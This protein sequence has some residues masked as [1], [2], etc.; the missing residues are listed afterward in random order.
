M[1]LC[2][3]RE[4]KWTIIAKTITLSGF[5][6]LWTLGKPCSVSNQ[7]SSG[8]DLHYF[9]PS[10]LD[11]SVELKKV[12]ISPDIFNEASSLTQYMIGSLS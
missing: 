3:K 9:C 2:K 10:V 8:S 12:C 1:I 4:K 7:I 6:D 11:D 5:P